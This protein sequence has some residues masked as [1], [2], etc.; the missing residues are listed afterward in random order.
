MAFR[1]RPAGHA[2]IGSLSG[3]AISSFV[4]R[5]METLDYKGLFFDPDVDPASPGFQGP[6][7][8]VFWH[9]YIPFLFYLRGHCRIAM[10]L[11]KH[12]DAEWLSQAA[13]HMGFSIVRGSSRRGGDAA[14]RELMRRGRT[15]NLAITPDGPRGPRRQLASGAIYVS[16]ALQIP[17]VPVGLGYDSPTRLPTW[18][19][20]AVPRPGSRARAVLGPAL[21]VP[22]SLDRD[23]IESYRKLVE[24]WLTWASDEA[25]AWAASG[26]SYS[27]Q[28]PAERKPAAP[29][30]SA[31]SAFRLEYPSSEMLPDRSGNDPPQ[32][33]VV[34]RARLVA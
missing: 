28:V 8:Y 32:R 33:S 21:Q 5:W 11:S 30:V 13:R 16:S 9:E 4:T 25:E 26:R 10:L 34:D 15:E 19:R 20:F 1:L 18:D 24:T 22:Q 31:A 7:I 17:I 27:N 2:G 3:L 14:L 23:G 29:R 12:Q 6:A